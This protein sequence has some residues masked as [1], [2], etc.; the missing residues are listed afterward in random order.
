MRVCTLLAIMAGLAL[1][2]PA[3]LLQNN[4]FEDGTLTHWTTS[5][6]VVSTDDP[7]S[8]TYCAFVEGNHWLKQEFTPTDVATIT[9]ITFWY[10]QPEMAIFAFDLFYG[11]SDYDEE[12]VFVSSAGWVEYDMT[13]FLRPAGNLQAIRVFG[14]SGGGTLP[15]YSY[16][17]DASVMWDE[18]LSLQQSTFGGIKAL[19]GQ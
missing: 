14:Y 5:A 15:D 12:I 11:Q 6:W 4:G 16:F 3:E 2:A 18:A 7:H 8:G 13:Y 17:D 10:K 9:S 1:S 19:L